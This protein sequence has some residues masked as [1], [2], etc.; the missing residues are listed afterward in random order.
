MSSPEVTLASAVLNV[1]HTCSALQQPRL[2]HVADNGCL[3]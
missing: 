2:L 1:G 3:Q